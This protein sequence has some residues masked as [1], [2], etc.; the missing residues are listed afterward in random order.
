MTKV[1][2][3]ALYDQVWS[4]PLTKLAKQYGVSDV[5]LAKACRRAKI[6][7]PGVG[8]WAKVAAGKQPAR[9]QLPPHEIDT[10]EIDV[11]STYRHKFGTP[12]PVPPVEE[13][14]GL[15]DLKVPEEIQSSHPITELT[16]K[17]LSKTKP[18]SY[19]FIAC[20][21]PEG[22][23]LWVS[24]TQLPRALR[25]LDTVA[26]A[27]EQLG[28]VISFG[29]KKR[30]IYATVQ[31]ESVEFK[32]R[33]RSIRHELPPPPAKPNERS[34]D[35][36]LNIKTYR[37]ESG[38]QLVFQ[39]DEYLEGERKTWR[40]TEH[41]TLESKVQD[42]VRGFLVAGEVKKARTEYW[43]EWDRERKEEVARQA[44]I[45]GQQEQERKAI[46]AL[47]S[48]A[49]NWNKAALIS[50]Y[51]LHLRAELNR[52]GLKLSE[53]GSRWLKENEQRARQTDPTE[54]RI[55]C[56]AEPSHPRPI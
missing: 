10:L 47:V 50:S 40:D 44:E 55:A 7:L 12:A 3:Q 18:N 51:L 46:Q 42:I 2:R 21:P 29:E 11:A 15:S 36:L 25:I 5:A 28:C 56:L 16:R 43:A 31:G 54:G 9:A 39:I 8:H 49:E 4:E 24:E 35:A 30:N 32:L 37:Y 45:K 34:L 27:L 38:G 19:G 41:S 20:R 23:D 14:P 6:P 48:E 33:E 52:R 13:I 53:A 22:F 26:K 1:N 17:K